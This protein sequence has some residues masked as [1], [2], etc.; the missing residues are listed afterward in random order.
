MAKTPRVSIVIP[1][2]RGRVDA[3]QASIARQTLQPLDVH[4]IEGVVPSGRARNLGAAKARGDLILFVD[5]DAV[6]GNEHVIERLAAPFS[7]PGA[8]TLGVT[9]SAKILPPDVGWFQ[10]RV[11]YEIPRMI[12]AVV[13]E[14]VESNPSI[15]GYGFTEITTTCAMVH[16]RAFDAVGG[17]HEALHRGVDTEFF[18]QVRKRDFRFW[19][20]A[21]T[22]VYHPVP[23]TLRD[24]LGKFHE[25]GTWHAQEAMLNP[26][27]RI[28]PELRN[29]LMA[30]AYV[31]ARAL[32]LVP[33]V[34][35]PRSRAYRRWE[36]GFKPLKALASFVNAC[37]Y[38]RSAVFRRTPQR[39]ALEAARVG[40]ALES[41]AP[42]APES[43]PGRSP[44]T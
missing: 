15:D 24:L 36:L 18:F 34:F 9:G 14:D 28:G 38:A 23:A 6:L 27:R 8:Q 35:V 33:N 10:R 31:L 21:D 37:G 39:S 40:S 12:H 41:E 16:R 20:I 2:F 11:A 7:R 32:I 5:D 29:P 22:W 19:L 26:E 4:V 30:L 1:S 25:M 13:D 17:F 3:L 44:R 42:A 43:S